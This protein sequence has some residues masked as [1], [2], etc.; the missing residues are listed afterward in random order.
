MS[1]FFRFVTIPAT[2]NDQC[3]FRHSGQVTN[4]GKPITRRQKMPY[5]TISWFMPV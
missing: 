1:H 5:E 4:T 3:T 2:P